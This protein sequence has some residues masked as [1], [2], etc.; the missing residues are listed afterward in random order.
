MVWD[1]RVAQTQ[2]YTMRWLQNNSW[3]HHLHQLSCKYH[4]AKA[5]WL[6]TKWLTILAPSL[7]TSET[8]LTALQWCL[9]P[10]LQILKY[11]DWTAFIYPCTVYKPNSSCQILLFKLFILK[12]HTT[13][14][15]LRVHTCTCWCIILEFYWELIT[16]VNNGNSLDTSCIFA[17]TID[18]ALEKRWMRV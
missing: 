12:R 15:F 6:V 14:F 16:A 13:H 7:Q 18:R 3:P 2:T 8:F 9:F 11:P 4:F 1:L 5:E 10:W 17:Q